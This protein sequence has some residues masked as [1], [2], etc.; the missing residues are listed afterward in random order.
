MGGEKCKIHFGLL[1]EIR[2]QVP[3]SKSAYMAGEFAAMVLMA[4]VA[5]LTGLFW[6]IMS[7]VALIFIAP[8]F[9]IN[10]PGWIFILRQEKGSY[11][12]LSQGHLLS[13]RKK[14]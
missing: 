8:S 7:F 2:S 1:I 5:V 9:L 3:V 11:F 12:I 10:I 14:F 13:L 4:V 6:N